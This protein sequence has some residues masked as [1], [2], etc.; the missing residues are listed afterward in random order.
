MHTLS[1]EMKLN[2][3]VYVQCPEFNFHVWGK[4]R[5]GGRNKQMKEG[6]RKEV[7]GRGRGKK[8]GRKVGREGG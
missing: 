7:G 1:L 5:R 6:K 4:K 3:K 8:Q 2:G